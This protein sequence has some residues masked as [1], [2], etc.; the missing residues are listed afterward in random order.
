[1]L[2]TATTVLGLAAIADPVAAHPCFA[3]TSETFSCL[4]DKDDETFVCVGF[5][6]DDDGDGRY[7]H[8]EENTVV[9]S[10]G[11]TLEPSGN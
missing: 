6:D 3:T 7:D 5:Y 10:N 2:A 11:K 9:C 8:G 4:E 1:M